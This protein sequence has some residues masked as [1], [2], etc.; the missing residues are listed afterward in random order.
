MNSGQ[1]ARVPISR[2]VSVINGAATGLSFLINVTFFLWLSRYLLGQVDA[3]EYQYLPIVQGMLVLV[4]LISTIFASSLGRYVV[5]AYGRDDQE[6]VTAIASTMLPVLASVA[7]V[8]LGVGAVV[9]W[10]I[11]WLL[12]GVGDAK[13]LVQKMLAVLVVG[14]S[15]RLATAVLS[16]GFFV[17]Q[18]FVIHSMISLTKELVRCALMLVLLLNVSTSVLWVVV[19]TVSA[20]M[21]MRLV[22]IACTR[23]LVPALVFRASAIDWSVVPELLAFGT[24]NFLRRLGASVRL[25]VTPILLTNFG[26]PLDVI[27]LSLGSFVDARMQMLMQSILHPLTPPLVAMHAND[28]LDRLRAAYLNGGRY[29]LWL[30]TMVAAPLL[31]FRWEVVTLYL[32]HL[33]VG[34]PE[35]KVDIAMIVTV[36]TVSMLLLPV[37]SGLTMLG[38]IAAAQGRLRDLGIRAVVTHGV[39]LIVTVYCVCYLKMGVL[40]A[41]VGMFPVLILNPLLVLPMGHAVAA[42]PFRVWVAKTLVPGLLPACIAG[43]VW[44]GL[45]ELIQPGD[46]QTLA[47]CYGIG[48][49][50]FVGAVYT[51]AMVPQE[52]SDLRRLL[53]RLLGR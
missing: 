8:I 29:S 20:E 23:V 42:T 12:P 31:V 24:W 34:V 51:L 40:G 43:L 21:L 14:V 16:V 45:R 1:K 25:A 15:F 7:L 46:W 35:P 53:G 27:S 6:R 9:V 37:R 19:A 2:K 47:L 41:V 49:A 48:A 10:Q 33:N 38:R 18:K 3:A 32:G 17:R 11:E 5:E 13:L 22:E 52:R 30:S 39:A 26:S 4:P 44:W 36:L 28:Q 50:V